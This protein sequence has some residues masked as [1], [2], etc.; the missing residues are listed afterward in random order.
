MTRAHESTSAQTASHLVDIE[1]AVLPGYA[2]SPAV[3]PVSPPRHPCGMTD[4]GEG[5]TEPPVV[6]GPARS[7]SAEEDGRAG[8]A[9]RFDLGTLAAIGAVIASVTYVLLNS[10]YLEFYGSLGIRPEDVGLDRIA[11]LGRTFGL[12]L[13]ALLIQVLFLGYF[14]YR[15]LPLD[16]SP[17]RR[18]LPWR[19]RFRERRVLDPERAQRSIRWRVVAP[20]VA[21]IVAFGLLSLAVMAATVA[22]GQRAESVE[23]GTPIGPLRV[24]PLLLV[25]TNADAARAYWLDK[26]LPKPQLLDDPWLLYL[27]SSNR[28]AVFIA[29]GTTVI[30]PAD[31]VIPQILTTRDIREASRG[32][33][34]ERKAACAAREP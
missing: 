7:M 32:G 20:A 8:D 23:E 14:V 18:R 26:D 27:G 13:I 6:A 34:A 21:I 28:V 33:A 31:K 25:D 29:C 22:V 30:V 12:V 16:I 24:G 2:G 15:Y 1:L 17:R 5:D 3:E 9:P 4:H 19:L 10:A 11:I